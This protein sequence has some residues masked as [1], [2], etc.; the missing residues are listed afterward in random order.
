VWATLGIAPSA[1]LAEIK[2]AF[3]KRAL[4]T[5]PDQGGD[6]EAF[7]AVR[8]AYDEALRRGRRRDARP[9]ARR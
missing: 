3:R 5:H 8:E 6:A 9:R 2:Q 1:S 4:E 7:R